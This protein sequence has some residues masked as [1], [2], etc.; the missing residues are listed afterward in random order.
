MD[1]RRRGAQALVRGS[2][3]LQRFTRQDASP[4]VSQDVSARESTV[5]RRRR[6]AEGQAAPAGPQEQQDGGPGQGGEFQE[7]PEYEYGGESGWTP[8]QR[9]AKGGGRPW[10]ALTPLQ[11]R[12]ASKTPQ[13]GARAGAASGPGP[14]PPPRSNRGTRPAPTGA[15]TGDWIL[16]YLV[17]REK[18]IRK[19]N[20]LNIFSIQVSTHLLY[21]NYP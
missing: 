7:I 21:L 12:S 10:A 3:V 14:A 1:R 5:L 6:G 17:Y 11:P 13:P 16:G 9:P 4:G 18:K 2:C 19:K 8:Q 15:K 20:Y